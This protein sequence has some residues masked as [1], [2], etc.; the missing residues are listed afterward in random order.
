MTGALELIG[1]GFAILWACSVGV[2]AACLVI[3][4]QTSRIDGIRE[5]RDLQRQ[6][7]FAGPLL[8][9]RAELAEVAEA[10]RLADLN[11]AARLAFGPQERNNSDIL[12]ELP[13]N[14]PDVQEVTI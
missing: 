11:R 1:L 4:D 7:H 6:E 10:W 2:V 3:S 13:A 9:S 8:L 5:L 12:S 14:T